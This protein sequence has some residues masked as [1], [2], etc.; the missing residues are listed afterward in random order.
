MADLV[1]TE[2]N[3][4]AGVAEGAADRGADESRSDDHHT[5]DSALLVRAS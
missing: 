2:V 3:R 1:I 4:V 5:V